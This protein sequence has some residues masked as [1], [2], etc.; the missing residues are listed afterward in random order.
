M[1]GTIT[2]DVR[3]L[4]PLKQQLELVA[5]PEPLRRRLLSRTARRVAADIRKRVR[6][7]VDINGNPFA[8]RKRIRTKNRK[9]LTRLVQAKRLK[10]IK[11]NGYEA[12]IGWNDPLQGIIAARHHYGTTE[13]VSA[14][15]YSQESKPEF[16]DKPATKRQARA[17]L[18]AGFRI[19]KKSGKGKKAPTIKW[20]QENMTIATAGFAVR[21]LGNWS[22]KSSWN[23]TLPARPFLGASKQEISNHIETI[24]KQMKQ[25]IAYV[26]R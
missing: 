12:V 13:R 8:E 26:P 10:T 21:Q 4:L 11:N 23:T 9:M 20:I 24:M 2:V 14:A 6:N 15:R 3:G 18:Q 7:Q 5:M 17:L 1:S 16:Y 22:A 19:K 25:E